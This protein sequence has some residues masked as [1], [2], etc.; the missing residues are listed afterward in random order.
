MARPKKCRRICSLPAVSKFKP[1]GKANG[2]VTL[3]FDEYE[4]IRQIDYMGLTHE[5]CANQMDVARSTVTSVYETARKKLADAMINVKTICID[6]GD[7]EIC[8]KNDACCGKCGKN[9]CGKCNHGTCEKCNG[10]CNSPGAGC[11]VA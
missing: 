9:K 1:A 11:F 8:D 3:T 7:F 2:T 10:I 5:E 6:G 4:T